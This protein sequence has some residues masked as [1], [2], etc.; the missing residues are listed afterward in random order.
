MRAVCQCRVTPTTVF[1]VSALLAAPA[2]G[3]AFTRLPARTAGLVHDWSACPAVCAIALRAAAGCL[4]AAFV[5]LLFSLLA[6]AFYKAA[7]SRLAGNLFYEALALSGAASLVAMG[8]RALRAALPFPLNLVI[9]T[10]L[11]VF[12]LILTVPVAVWIAR[13]MSR[14]PDARRPRAEP[15]PGGALLVV[16]A[17]GLLLLALSVMP[18]ALDP[19]ATLWRYV[20]DMTVAPA[21]SLGFVVFALRTLL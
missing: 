15:V 21:M 3:A 19:F 2:L 14:A 20:S 5:V 16:S 8:D 13:C 10:L 1:T 7:P 4:V 18:E 12:L 17:P 9:V 6:R 11:L